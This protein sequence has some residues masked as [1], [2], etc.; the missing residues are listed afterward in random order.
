MRLYKQRWGFPACAGGIDGT[1]IAIQAP[2][3]NHV[4]YVNRKN[5]HSIVMQAVVD[6]QYLFRDIVVG[7]PGSVHNA[8]VL[9][10][11]EFY[12]RGLKLQ[13]FDV[14]M[15]ERILGVDLGP[16]I[17]GDSAYPLLEW[18]MKAY[19]ENINTPN[20][21]RHFNYKLSRARMTVENTFGRW[22]GR[23][24]RFNKRVDMAVQSVTYLV[25]ASCIVHNICEL[26][27]NDFFKSGW[28]CATR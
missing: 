28:K 18:L 11:S 25:A 5:Y 27:R 23:F 17:L 19:P 14:N 21:Q 4:D 10:N 1:H 8:W 13:L 12:N 9:S 20:W 16:I 7:W 24:R 3:E 22:K 2:V 6:C 15:K 26:R